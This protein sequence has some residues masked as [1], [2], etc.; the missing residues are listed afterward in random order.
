MLKT[1]HSPSVIEPEPIIG[2]Q[3]FLS[4]EWYK[5]LIRVKSV[6]QIKFPDQLV[7]KESMVIEL[8]PKVG[9]GVVPGLWLVA[10]LNINSDVNGDFH[11]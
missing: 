9:E 6:N 7:Q 10:T 8:Q 11:Q 3:Q 2:K 4:P 5:E 1:I